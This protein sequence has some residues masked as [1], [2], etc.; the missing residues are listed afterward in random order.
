MYGYRCKD[1]ENL[2]HCKRMMNMPM[3]NMPMRTCQ[4]RTCL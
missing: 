1:C 4:W 2:E 3:E